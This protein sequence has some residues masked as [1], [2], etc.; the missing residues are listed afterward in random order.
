MGGIVKAGRWCLRRSRCSG[1][2]KE[3]QD[4]RGRINAE[5]FMREDEY[6]QSLHFNS[7]RMK[8]GSIDNMSL[9]I[10]LAIDDATKESIGSSSNVGLVGPDGHL[11]AILRRIEIYKHSKEERIARTWGTTAPGLP[12]VEEVIASAGNWLIGEKGFKNPILLLHHLGGFTKAELG[13]SYG[14][15]QQGV[16]HPLLCKTT[17]DIIRIKINCYD[18]TCTLFTAIAIY[19]VL[20]DGVL[21]PKT[22]IVSIF[23][24]PMHYAGP[25]EVQWH[26]KAR[27]NAAAN[28]YIVG[29]DPAVMFMLVGDTICTNRIKLYESILDCLW[30]NG[31]EDGIF[32]TLLV[33]KISSLSLEPKCELMQEPVRTLLMVL[34]ALEDGKSSS[35][36]TRVCKQRSQQS[37]RLPNL[38][39]STQVI[40]IEIKFDDGDKPTHVGLT[41]LN[42]G[43]SQWPTTKDGEPSSQTINRNTPLSVSFHP[44]H[45]MC[46]ISVLFE[47]IMWLISTMKERTMKVL[48]KKCRGKGNM[49]FM[50]EEDPFN[51]RIELKDDADP[52]SST[53]YLS[54][55]KKVD[56]P[57]SV[58]ESNE[59][60]V[61]IYLLLIELKVDADPTPS[62]IIELKVDADPTLS[63]MDL[64]ENKNDDPPLSVIK[65]N[66][67]L[68]LIYTFFDRI[69]LKVDADPTPSAM[70]LSENKKVDPPPSMME[71][72]EMSVLIYLLL[73]ELKVDAD[74]TS[75]VMDLS[76]Q[77]KVDPPYFVMESNEMLV[78]I[79]LLL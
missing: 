17:T 67:M 2:R 66:K 24:S 74:P 23:P 36:I 40:R 33:P 4:G 9:P 13:C 51:V 26:A 28:F 55:N 59:V 39:A 52:T 62:A 14:T 7:L 18:G 27:I 54:E 47:G 73:I 58:M 38:K 35:N 1:E 29:R 60:S 78:L 3:G 5:G 19:D 6:L 68:V 61:L 30:Y 37:K 63:A 64:S 49:A 72:N 70:D 46:C 45:H 25:K 65:S 69:E 11:V 21:D 20:E 48:E 32:L 50:W 15:T 12:Y 77:K 10:V 42:N 43:S 44:T 16:S 8:D 41:H 34:C 75:S 71:S 53:M 79:Y 22:T 31:K 76:E 57:L 56:P